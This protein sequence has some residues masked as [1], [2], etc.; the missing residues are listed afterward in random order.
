MSTNKFLQQTGVK[1]PAFTDLS[2][3]ASAAQQTVMIGDSGSGGVQ[4]A[5]PA[6]GAGD[7]AANKFLKADA[8]W[9]APS[10][11]STD[12]INVNSVI[13]VT[14]FSITALVNGVGPVGE[15]E[16]NTALAANYTPCMYENTGVNLVSSLRTVAI[17]YYNAT[18]HPLLVVATMGNTQASV[19]Y[20]AFADASS[21]PSTVVFKGIQ[22]GA[23]G[24]NGCE[25]LTFFVLPGQYY[26]I[27]AS[28]GTTTVFGWRELQLPVGTFADSGNIAGRAVA[29]V[30]QNTSGQC[31]F[32]AA[33]IGSVTTAS[34][35]QGLSDTTPSPANVVC[36][37]TNVSGGT[38][39]V[40][41]FMIVPPGHYYKVTAA[42]GSASLWHEYTWNIPVTKSND[43]ILTTGT[44]QTRSGAPRSI[45]ATAGANVAT[46]QVQNWFNKRFRMLWVV[47]IS[48]NSN[49]TGT[50]QLLT[51]SGIPPFTFTAVKGQ[52]STGQARTV[53]GPVNP[54]SFYSFLDGSGTGALT[55]SHW[56]EYELG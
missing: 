31:M 10:G 41:V 5:A 17:V 27:T 48:S 9:A 8:T 53:G 51:D 28:A 7:A 22:S 15:V 39:T 44:G 18:G 6:P 13:V 52:N 55:Q 29:T 38:N 19:T 47:W 50:A 40:T 56:W 20:T 26:K 32:V 33:Q 30:Y 54:L 43:L 42:T 24:S 16:V 49:T 14:P 2:G 34:V 1:Q 37:V 12:T 23:T 46:V 25:T 36:D 11:G 4:G 21:S 35:V 45:S 3:A